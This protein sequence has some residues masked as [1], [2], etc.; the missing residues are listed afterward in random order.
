MKYYFTGYFH[1]VYTLPSECHSR[2]WDSSEQA[3]CFQSSLVRF[4]CA[5]VGL[6]CCDFRD[7]LLCTLVVPPGRA[8]SVSRDVDAEVDYFNFDCLKRFTWVKPAFSSPLVYAGRITLAKFVNYLLLF[9]T[10]TQCWTTC[11]QFETFS[12]TKSGLSM[13]T[14]QVTTW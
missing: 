10:Q 13:G 3:I 11:W 5:V 2:N 12:K 9:L 7:A 6:T 4:C 14:L 1:V 8:V